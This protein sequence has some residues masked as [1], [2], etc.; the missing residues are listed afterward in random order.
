MTYTP[1][2]WL[3]I[4]LRYDLVQPDLDDKDE[5]FHVVSPS[6]ILSSKFASNEQI[7]IG[8]SYY[9]LG[10]DVAPGFPH[11]TL[12]PDDHLLRLSAIMWW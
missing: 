12:V 10:P 1:K 8:Y 4:D 11:E 6:I 9:K 7:V 3:G 5:S 2:S